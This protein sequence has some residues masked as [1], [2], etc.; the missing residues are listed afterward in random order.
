MG[1]KMFRA[2]DKQTGTVVWETELPGGTSG[3]PMTYMVDGKQYVAVTVG[4]S[5]IRA[6][7]IALA[8]P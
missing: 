2:L 4:W 5:D 3:V 7:L 8:L 1:G 6:E